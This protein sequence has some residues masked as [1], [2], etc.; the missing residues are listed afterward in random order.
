MNKKQT[1]KNIA[2]AAT[3][4]GACLIGLSSISLDTREDYQGKQALKELGY[5]SASVSNARGAFR[6]FLHDQ[7]WYYKFNAKE[8]FIKEIVKKRQF[9]A[10]SI[11]SGGCSS[12]LS[13]KFGSEWL[14]PQDW[15]W[16]PKDFKTGTCYSN[17]E[18]SPGN[19]TDL[20]YHPQSGTAFV[21]SH[22]N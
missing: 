4:S 10:E 7:N 15:W 13:Q 14:R 19:F 22:N 2:L 12:M 1:I 8:D 21:Y 18:S 6:G 17:Y 11:D 3:I 5:S 16:N 20:I 9:K